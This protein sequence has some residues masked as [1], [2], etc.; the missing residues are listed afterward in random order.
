[1]NSNFEILR[2]FCAIKQL[3]PAVSFEDKSVKAKYPADA[4]N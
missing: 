2:V 1:M 4:Q 3:I